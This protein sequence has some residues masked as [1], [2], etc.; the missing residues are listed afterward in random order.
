MKTAKTM[1][2]PAFNQRVAGSSPA[3]LI[4]LINKL[5]LPFGSLNCF[6]RVSDLIKSCAERFIKTPPENE[7]MGFPVSFGECST[8]AP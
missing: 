2:E 6:S 1:Q 5:R 7:I 4:N 8:C 3:R